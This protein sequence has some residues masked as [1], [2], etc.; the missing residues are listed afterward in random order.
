MAT[1]ASL[2]LNSCGQSPQNNTQ[3]EVIEPKAKIL[4]VV[5]VQRDFFDP[6][7]SLYVSGS[8][9]LPDKIAAVAKNY[10]AVVFTLDWH[11]ADHCSFSARGGMWPSHC[12]AFTQG[13]GIADAFAPVLARGEK[14]VQLFLKGQDRD[15][16]QYGAFETLENEVIREWFANCERVDVCGIAGDYCVKESTGCLLNYVPAEKVGILVDCVCSIDDGSAL[17]AFIREKGL[18]RR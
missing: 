15:K 18:A 4:V 6:S 1:I 2:A 13:S 5:D 10:D 3:S 12:V 11:P 9:T 14:D 17:E 16:E 8:E 7:G